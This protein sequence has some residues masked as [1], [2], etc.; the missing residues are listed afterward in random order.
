[1]KEKANATK[2]IQSLKDISHKI[3]TAIPSTDPKKTGDPNAVAK[4][5]ASAEVKKK[6]EK[7]EAKGK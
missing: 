5:E 6:R 4:T 3:T 2:T 7:K 1:M